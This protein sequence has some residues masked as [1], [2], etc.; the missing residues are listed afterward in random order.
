[1]LFKIN[2]HV[3]LFR[4][5]KRSSVILSETGLVAFFRNHEFLP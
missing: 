5:N 3:K 4:E 1:M 2:V